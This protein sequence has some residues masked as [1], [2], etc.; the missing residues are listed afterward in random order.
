MT[1]KGPFQPKPFCDSMIFFHITGRPLFFFS[2]VVRMWRMLMFLP[3]TGAVTKIPK[4]N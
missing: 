3:M 1:F 2:R 4:A